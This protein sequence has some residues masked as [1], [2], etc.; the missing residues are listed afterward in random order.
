VYEEFFELSDAPFR[1]TPD[2][3]FLFLSPKHAEALAHLRLGLTEPGGFVCITGEIGTGKTTVLRTFLAD[4]GPE[5]ATAFIFN[6]TLSWEDML[7]R[8]ARDLGV[9]VAET[10]HA[11][12]MDALNAHLLAT[13]KD[14]RIA[15]VVIDE[16][17]AIPLEGLERLRLLSN[18]ETSTEKLLRLVLVGQPQLVTLLLDPALAQL[19]QRITLRWHL[20]A[21]TRAETFAY[22]RHRLQVAGGPRAMRLFTRPALRLLHYHARGVPRLVN[23]IAHRAL[24][25]AYVR[26]RRRVTFGSVRQAYREIRAVPLAARSRLWRV[27]WVVGALALALGLG[28]TQIPDLDERLALLRRGVPAPAVTAAAP[29]PAVATQIAAPQTAPVPRPTPPSSA[30]PPPPTLPRPLPESH[31]TTPP[32]AAPVAPPDAAAQADA[33]AERPAPPAPPTPPSTAPAPAAVA[34]AP[35]PPESPA[36][37]PAPTI[38]FEKRLASLGTERSLR[39]AVETVLARWNVAPL[40]GDETPSAASLEP[41]A[42]R[43]KLEDLR[44]TGNLSMLRLLDLPAVLELYLGGVRQPLYVAVT[45]IGNDAVTL[46]LGDE[47]LQIPPA[48]LDRVWFGDA[49]VLWRDFEWLGPTFGTESRGDH[50]ERLQ[51]LLAR[52]GVYA[53]PATGWFGE[54]T[55]DAVL[56]F[57]RSR[58][59]ETDCRVGRLTRIA[60]YGAAGGYD[61]PGLVPHGTATAA[62]GRAGGDA[63]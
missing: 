11:D 35:A 57:Q 16:A 33:A 62:T 59:L 53:G 22:V 10:G 63:S 41:V 48:R 58:R 31:P 39:T 14:G 47:E 2:P 36:A 29:G 42:H 51:H 12:V 38:D 56:R 8:I 34:T 32:P 45:A 26:R 4:L 18:L 9:P 40:G 24:L 27:G 30:P 43:R 37:A 5:V 54:A 52:A 13:R 49:H 46:A 15:V 60:L 21:L 55:A 19:N 28:A 6:P 23:M 20:R 17:Q 61:K 1:L 7:Q 50:V 25:A 44:L 3:H